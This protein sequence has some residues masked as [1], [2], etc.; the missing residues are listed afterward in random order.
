MPS[1]LAHSLAGLAAGWAL[2]RPS[3]GSPIKAFPTAILAAVVVAALP[4][5]DLILPGPHRAWTHGVG[6]TGFVMIIAAAVTGWVTGRVRWRVVAM[7]G[8][9]HA[10]HIVM[11]WLGTDR[12]PPAGLEALWPF[13]DRFYI[14]GWDWFPAVERRL[15]RPDALD[16]NARAAVAE[17]VRMVPV[18]AVAWTIRRTRRTR[19]RTSDRAVPPPPSAAAAGRGDTSD[20]RARP[21][22]P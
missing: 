2:D 12:L 3:P 9:A 11:D 21:A 18:T 19:A 1:P 10:S 20:P 14:S 5:V 15:Y 8:V 16:I 7:L 22:A 4:D 13:S 6:T 17:L